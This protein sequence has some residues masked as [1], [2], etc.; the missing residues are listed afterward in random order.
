MIHR[1]FVWLHRWTGLLIAVF[2]VIVGITGTILAFRSTIDRLLNPGYYAEVK[3]GQTSLDPASLA[4]RAEAL[5]PHAKPGFFS[6]GKDQVSISL[7]PRKDPASG[8]P[9]EL[10]FTHL[11]LDPYTGR[12]LGRCCTDSS[13]R[14]NFLPFIYEL[15]TTVAMGNTGALILGI[16]ALAWTLDCFVGIYLTLPRRHGGFWKRWKYAWDIKWRANAFRINF[17][18][19]R[20]GGLWSWVLLLVFAWSSVMLSLRPVYERVTK[21]VFDYRSD[22]DTISCVTLAQPLDDPKLGWREAQALGE[23][24]MAQVAAQHNFT[25]TRPYGMAYI[26]EFGVYTYAVRGSND[27]RGEGWDTSIWID[28]NTGALRDVSLPYGQ[29]AGNTVSTVLWGLHYGDI[30]NFLPYRI[31]VAF[32]G[33]VLTVISLTGIY[34]WWRKRRGRQLATLAKTK[35]Q[36]TST[37]ASIDI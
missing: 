23:R 24:A 9:Y 3:P 16:V 34:I 4:E 6:I 21:A 29:H 33:V 28:G 13:W 12:E 1:Y 8:K 26:P 17:D 27:I 35:I 10:G 18:L 22:A 20:A 30:C 2:L 19:H 5:V 15:H 37:A 32:F 31:L 14:V 7:R 36:D 25:I 11:I